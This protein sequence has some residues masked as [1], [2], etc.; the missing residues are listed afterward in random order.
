MELQRD[1]EQNYYD[2]KFVHICRNYH[3]YEFGTTLRA[4]EAVVKD[5]KVSFKECSTDSILPQTQSHLIEIR[6]DLVVISKEEAAQEAKELFLEEA[7]HMLD[8]NLEPTVA[9][10]LKVD[11]EAAMQVATMPSKQPNPVVMTSP[12]ENAITRNI[13]EQMSNFA[14]QN[15]LKVFTNKSR[16][17]KYNHSFSKYYTSQPDITVYQN[18]FTIVT[19]EDYGKV[20]YVHHEDNSDDVEVDDVEVDDVRK[21][22]SGITLTGETKQGSKETAL[23]QLLAGMDKTLGDMFNNAIMTDSVL[24]K[25]TM[26]GLCLKPGLNSCDVIK[27]DVVIG[28]RTTLYMGQNELKIS[29][30]VNRVFNQLLPRL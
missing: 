29:D 24:T 6:L 3:I 16:V 7:A 15:G 20:V 21:K 28:K 4:S 27:A 14:Q 10:K 13:V 11:V 25:L 5:L 2:G 1:E 26:Y 22:V 12:D 23:G 30:A 18:Q 17:T 9:K 19:T 8:T